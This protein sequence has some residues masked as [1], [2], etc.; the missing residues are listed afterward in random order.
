MPLTTILSFVISYFIGSIP[1]AYLVVK[2]TSNLDI[3]SEGSGNV[4]GRNALEVT[5]KKW[6]GIVVSLIDCLK[7]VVA[8]IIIRFGF[9]DSLSLIAAMAGVVFGHCFPVWLKFKGGRGL[10]TGAGVFFAVSWIVVPLWLAA[11][12]LSEKITKNVHIASVMALLVI[13]LFCWLLPF[14]WMNIFLSINFTHAEIA[15]GGSIVAAIALVRHIEPIQ[16]L[17]QLKNHEDK[18]S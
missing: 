7:G 15:I 6:I 18:K 8:I 11:Y 3:R 2:W 10:A 13:P 17:I 16:E 9:G 12:F 4:G 5:G 1:T 14:D